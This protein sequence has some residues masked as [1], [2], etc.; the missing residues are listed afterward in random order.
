MAEDRSL[1]EIL[2]GI[3]HL[4]D[5]IHAIPHAALTTYRRTPPDIMLEHDTRAAANN[6]WCHMLAEAER[7][8]ASRRRVVLR[9]IRGMKV[10]LIEDI[11]VLRFKK[12]DEDGRSRNYPTP[13]QKKFDRGVA[14][15]G[16][17]PEAARISAGYV[18]NK[19]AT[20]IDWIMVARPNGRAMPHWCVAV[21]EPGS[22]ERYEVRYRASF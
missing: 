2:A 15:P 13:Q 7:R 20:D 9:D 3:D 1:E 11:A 18:L 21:N 6:V 14:L 16:L 19:A 10:W 12:L 4:L 5:D 8:F 17:P 22:P